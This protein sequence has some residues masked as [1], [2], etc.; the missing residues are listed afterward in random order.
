MEFFKECHSLCHTIPWVYLRIGYPPFQWMMYFFSHQS[1]QRFHHMQWCTAR[2]ELVWPCIWA[3]TSS[4]CSCWMV[5]A[6]TL[7]QLP[8]GNQTWPQNPTMWGR[9]CCLELCFYAHLGGFSSQ[10]WLLEGI[11]SY[12]RYLLSKWL[13]TRSGWDCICGA[14]RPAQQLF[15]RVN[16]TPFEGSP[17]PDEDKHLGQ[18]RNMALVGFF[19]LWQPHCSMNGF[20]KKP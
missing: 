15:S 14:G 18:A 11:L 19:H 9:F 12:G 16:R 6:Y 13:G 2:L 10:V 4:G 3:Y 1:L 7:L 8:F 20:I 17:C 5:A